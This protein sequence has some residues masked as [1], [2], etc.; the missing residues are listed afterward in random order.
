MQFIHFSDNSS[1]DTTDKYAKV[2]PLVRHLTKKFTEYF[3]PVKSL[4]HDEGMVGKHGCRQCIRMKPIR[5]GYKAWCL[6]T[7]DGYLVTFDLYQGRTYEGN[8]L[9]EKV[10]G[11]CPA[12]VLKTLIH[13]KK[14]N[15]HFHIIYILIISLL[16]FNFSQ[17]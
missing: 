5:F 4:S 6:N 8:E 11:K 1:L 2:R 13:C 10:F 7:D 9:N 3:Q 12:T 17:N 14:I 16:P 15:D